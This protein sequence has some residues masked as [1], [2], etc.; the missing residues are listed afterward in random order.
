M[1]VWVSPVLTIHPD[2]LILATIQR[3][4]DAAVDHSSARRRT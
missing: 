3:H 1:A 4:L 2:F